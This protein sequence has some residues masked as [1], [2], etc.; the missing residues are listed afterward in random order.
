M[1]LSPFCHRSLFLCCRVHWLRGHPRYLTAQDLDLL[2]LLALLVVDIRMERMLL[3][4]ITLL[5][6]WLSK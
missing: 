5:Y 3:M 6:K 1:I 2:L 4:R